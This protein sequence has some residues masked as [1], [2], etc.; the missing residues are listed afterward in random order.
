MQ[1]RSSHI[2]DERFFYY[3][4]GDTERTEITLKQ[5]KEGAMN[6]QTETKMTVKVTEAPT[7]TENP[8]QE[9]H[10]G[11]VAESVEETA[12]AVLT[13]HRLEVREDAGSVFVP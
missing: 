13:A 11:E 10:I 8:M 5:E 2:W 9:R 7:E 6:T 3:C 1:K 12:E 4:H